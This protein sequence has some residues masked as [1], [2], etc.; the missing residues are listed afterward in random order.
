MTSSL[1]MAGLGLFVLALA[2]LACGTDTGGQGAASAAPTAREAAPPAPPAGGK[3][4]ETSEAD[5][6]SL[7]AVTVEDPAEGREAFWQPE[8][9]ERLVAVEVVIG[10]VGTEPL[11]VNPLY[12]TLVDDRGFSHEV[13]LAALE[14]HDQL[15]VAELGPGEKVKGWVGF[16]L[17]AGA[18]PAYVKFTPGLLGTP[19]KAGL[20]E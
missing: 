20:E 12:A 3:L 16:A 2:M 10:N 19:V 4:G 8:A 17:E 14:E 1:R 5:G 9:G 15:A 7:A 11:S 13:E 6:C 18:K